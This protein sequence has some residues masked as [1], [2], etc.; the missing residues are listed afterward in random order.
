MERAGGT[1]V[2]SP[3]E[4]RATL[5]TRL[6]TYVNFGEICSAANPCGS[7]ALGP[8]I[9]FSLGGPTQTA[10]MFDNAGSWN[11]VTDSASVRGELWL[12]YHPLGEPVNL[13]VGLGPFVDGR[14]Q[15][16]NSP[17]RCD[18][19]GGILVQLRAGA[20]TRY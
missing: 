19:D 18:V 20:R 3:P 7:F 13:R 2:V 4:V 15:C 6:F 9:A 8:A 11:P 1:R 14:F 10:G 12:F 17:Q 5:S 16:A